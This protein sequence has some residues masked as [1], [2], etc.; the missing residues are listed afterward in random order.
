MRTESYIVEGKPTPLARPRITKNRTYNPQHKL[1]QEFGIY[2]QHQRPTKLLFSGPV[3]LDVTFYMCIPRSWSKKKQ[4]ALYGTFHEKRP[5][6]SNLLK[7]VEDGA[8]GVLYEDD[9][10]ISSVV[11][12]KVYSFKPRTEFTISELRETDEK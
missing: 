1:L 4:D 7:F 10:I 3:H 6:I 5:D 2:L 9:C 12:K 11:T 8:H